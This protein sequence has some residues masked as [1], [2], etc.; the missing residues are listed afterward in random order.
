MPKKHKNLIEKICEIDNLREAYRKTAKGRKKTFGYL[1]FKE[2]SEANLLIIRE[3]LLTGT[4]KIGKYKN[5]TVYEPKPRLISALCFKDRLVQHAICNIVS[6]IFENALLPQTFACRK[7]KGTH[8]GIKY[9]QSELRKH[10]YKY[11]LKTDYSKFFP[12]V[13]R[14]ILHEM[15][16]RKI[17]CQ[18]TLTALTEIIPHEGLGIP[19]GSLTSQLFANTYGDRVD[20]FI[21]FELKHKSWIRYMDDIVILGNDDALLKENFVR[22]K[23]FSKQKLCLEISKWQVNS[24]NKGINFLGYRIWKKFKLLR[25]SSVIKAKRKIARFVTNEDKDGLKKFIGAWSGHT[26]WANSYNLIKSLENKH[27][28]II[29]KNHQ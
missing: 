15:I 16:S 13:N 1:E 10:D 9:L 22:I 25:K 8:A 24:A 14:E 21:H 17:S 12:S 3:E 23:D 19:I 11:F 2:Y 26:K 28:I 20:R 18:K 7:D 29:K 5:F 27:V 6:P 4:Y